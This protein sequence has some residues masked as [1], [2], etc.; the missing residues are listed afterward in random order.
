[1]REQIEALIAK[2]RERVARQ[3]KDATAVADA[4][5]MCADDLAIALLDAAL[6]A[7]PVPT[8]SVTQDDL[9][10]AYTRDAINEIEHPDR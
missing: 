6:L 7:V 5:E 8:P 9:R 3:R 10:D 1:M 4:V 2:W